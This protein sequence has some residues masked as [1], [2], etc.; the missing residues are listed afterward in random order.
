MNIEH[1]KECELLIYGNDGHSLLLNRTDRNERIIQLFLIHDPSV[2][3]TA[4]NE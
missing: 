1:R 2:A 3:A 4:G